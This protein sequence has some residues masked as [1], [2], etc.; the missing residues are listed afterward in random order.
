MALQFIPSD[1]TKIENFSYVRE[2]ARGDYG[3]VSLVQNKVTKEQLALK[4]LEIP[5]K[6]EHWLALKKA[7]DL[8]VANKDHR[9]ILTIRNYK[10]ENI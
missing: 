1:L 2:L 3:T 8:M 7:L 4:V 5:K 10:P 9:A 6:E